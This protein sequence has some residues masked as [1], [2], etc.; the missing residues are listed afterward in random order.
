MKCIGGPLDGKDVQL[1]PKRPEYV[2]YEREPMTSPRVRTGMA[3]SDDAL[4][5]TRH[6]YTKRRV[7]LS[8]EREPL[9]FLAPERWN[10]AKAIRHQFTK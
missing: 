6:V 10:D 3:V 1:T 9:E 5:A 2:Y 4:I 7:H 8:G